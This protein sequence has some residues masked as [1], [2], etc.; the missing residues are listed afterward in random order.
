M[1]WFLKTSL[2]VLCN[3]T[4]HIDRMQTAIAVVTLLL[5]VLVAPSQGISE[6][7]RVRN[8]RKRFGSW[9]PN[10]PPN[11]QVETPAQRAKN[12]AREA[13]IMQI[14]GAQERWEN[15]MQFVSGQLVPKFTPTGFKLINT[16][17]H[18]HAK[19]KAAL[20][21]AL[22]DWDSIPLESSVDIVYGPANSK[23]LNIGQLAWDI[24]AD[25]LP[26][27]EE[28]A[29]GIKLRGTSS[30]GI[31]L[32]QNLS[33]LVMHYDKVNTKTQIASHN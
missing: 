7:E 14:P 26:L 1:C 23:F 18:V 15:W 24:N 3:V 9:P 5:V 27:H 13:E 4:I 28:W 19:L 10:G 29:G 25:L 30:Y 16:P 33:S 22:L 11:W 31:R 12:A 8:W 17:P 32:Y 21:Q 20:D 2:N 6:V